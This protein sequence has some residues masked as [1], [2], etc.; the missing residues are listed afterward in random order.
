V[1]PKVNVHLEGMKRS[2]NVV[3]AEATSSSKSLRQLAHQAQ[4][5]L[6]IESLAGTVML[7]GQKPHTPYYFLDF[8][9]AKEKI[10]P[11][12]IAMV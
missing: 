5:H 2:G 12:L 8:E 10:A 9:Q 4:I 3:L 6:K 7:C 11:S 1:L